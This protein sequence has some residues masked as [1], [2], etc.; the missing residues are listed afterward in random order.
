MGVDN[1]I[2]ACGGGGITAKGTIRQAAADF[3]KPSTV[4]ETGYSKVLTCSG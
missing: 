2:V 4:L 1:E 3:I